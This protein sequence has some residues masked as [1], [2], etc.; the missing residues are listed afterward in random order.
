M[1]LIVLGVDGVDPEILQETMEKRDVPNWEKLDQEAVYR[2]L[3]S[4]I[5]AVT[6]PAWITMFSG[7][8][9]EKFDSYHLSQVNLGKWQMERPNSWQFRGEFIWDNIEEVE[10]GL[11]Y[12]P[13]TTPAY[14]VNG[15]M[16]GGFPTP[17]EF[18]FYPESLKEKF[19]HLERKSVGEYSRSRKKIEAELHNF[20]VEREIADEMFSKDQDVFIS[21]IRMTDHASHFADKKSQV[22]DCYEKTDEEIGKYLELA[23]ENDANL[24]VVSDHGFFH[25]KKKFNISRFL[26]DNG[27]MN[28]KEG[29][30][31]KE[32]LV[33]RLAQPLLDTPLKKYLRAANEFVQNKFGKD[34]SETGG[35]ILDSIERDSKVVPKHFG[36]GKDC[37]LKVQD[38]ENKQEIIDN[39]KNDLQNL[40]RNGRP[41]VKNIWTGDELYE[42]KGPEMAFRTTEEYVIETSPS[43]MVFS[44]TN[45]FTHRENG[46]FYGLGP[47]I[48][49][50]FEDDLD[51]YDIAPMIYS[52]LDEDSPD[53]IRDPKS[54]VR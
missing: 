3:P 32:S 15:V 7:Y 17:K 40:E 9:P 21:V 23:E 37:V 29:E 27:Y 13:G 2:D 42:G 51:I 28:L 48:N 38:S 1:D 5:P 53:G 8:G 43:S 24:L 18:D 49:T 50:D 41:V 36:L 19:V 25:A 14:E 33:Y 44:K 35:V 6:I 26:T 31:G 52:M 45:S 12:V 30:E 22:L 10:F 34:F 11:H 47:D 39:L 20:E 54:I 46:I 16:R 4:T